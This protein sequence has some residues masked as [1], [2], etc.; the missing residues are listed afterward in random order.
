MI[1]TPRCVQLLADTQ[2]TAGKMTRKELFK[3]HSIVKTTGYQILK[4]KSARCSER[5]YDRGRKRV[6]A[7]F[8]CEAIKAVE[9]ANFRFGTTSHFA[10]ASAIGLAKG[11]ERV[12][13]R[14][15]AEFGVETY[16]T[17]QK[18]Y[19]IKSLIKRRVI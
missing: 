12:I 14:N 18:K 15:I 7:P 13:Q 9:N 11:S 3:L 6:L 1:D 10:N 2:A 5:I 16:I 17:Q 19:I 4:E 8:E